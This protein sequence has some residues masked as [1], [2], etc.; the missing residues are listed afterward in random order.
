VGRRV[1]QLVDFAVA[2]VRFYTQ[3]TNVEAIAHHGF[4]D[5]Y[6]TAIPTPNALALVV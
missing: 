6:N 3:Q 5:E 1:E 4:W 2:N